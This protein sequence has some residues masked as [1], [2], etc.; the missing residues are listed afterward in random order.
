MHLAKHVPSH[1]YI[2]GQ[3]ALFSYIGQTATCYNCNATH[4]LLQHSHRQR[5]KPMI[6]SSPAGPY[7]HI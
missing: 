7:S 6:H 1:T 5:L 3:R 2:A 4:H